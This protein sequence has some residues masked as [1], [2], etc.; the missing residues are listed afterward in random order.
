MNSVIQTEN[1]TRRFGQFI[2]VDAIHLE[3]NK[4]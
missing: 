4:G 2:A 3:V 1:L